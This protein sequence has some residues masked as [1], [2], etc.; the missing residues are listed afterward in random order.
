MDNIKSIYNYISRTRNLY[1]LRSTLQGLIYLLIFISVSFFILVLTDIAIHFSA[2]FL[3]IIHNTLF[4]LTLLLAIFYLGKPFYFWFINTSKYDQLWFAH[5]IGNADDTIDDKLTNILELNNSDIDNELIRASISQKL[6]V[7]N[8]SKINSF[9]SFKVLLKQIYFFLFV[10]FTLSL[11]AFL[12]PDSFNYSTQR[13]LPIIKTDQTLPYEIEIDNDLLEVEK[14]SNF[15]LRAKVIGMHKPDN[16]YIEIGGMQYFMNDSAQY[17]TYKLNSLKQDV[18]FKLVNEFYSSDNYFI[19]CIPVPIL[20]NISLQVIPP[21]YTGS[22]SFT[23]S[24]T[25]NVVFP[26]GSILQWNINTLDTDSLFLVSDSLIYFSNTEDNNY[27]FENRYFKDFNYGLLLKNNTR[28]KV[29]TIFFSA[30]VIPDQFPN[31][32]IEESSIDFLGNY[33]FRGEIS[34][35]YGFHQFDFIIKYEEETIETNIPLFSGNLSQSFQ[36][37]GTLKDF[38]ASIKGSDV[39]LVLR[40]KDNDPFYPFKAS[41]SQSLY[42][43]LPNQSELNDLEQRKVSMLKDKLS[44]GTELLEQL[45]REKANIRKKLLDNSSKWEKKQLSDQLQNTNQELNR[46]SEQINQLRED[47]KEFNKFDNKS[48]LFSKKQQ[49]EE[50]LNKLMDEELK[51]LMEELQKLQEEIMNNDMPKMD[52]VDISMDELEKHLDQNL[53]MLKRY[54]IEKQQDEVIQELKKLAQEFKD[55]ASPKTA[56]DIEKLKSQIDSTFKKHTDNLD[57]NKALEDPYEL[58]DFSKEKESIQ[59]QKD[60]INSNDDLKDKQKNP[61]DELEDLANKMEMNMDMAMQQQQG[62]DAAMI[63]DLLENLLHFSF[64]QEKYIEQFNNYEQFNLNELK[65]NQISLEERF[66]SLEDSLNA[67]MSRN[68][69]VALSIGNQIKNIKFNFKAIGGTFEAERFLSIQ[70]YQQ[71]IMQSANEL[72]L[73]LNESL[74][75]MNSMSGTGGQCK[76]KGSKSKPGMSGMKKKQEGM[77]KSLQ[78]MIDQL[79]KGS[80]PGEGQKGMSE[81]LSKM[82]GEQ[83]KLQQMLQQMMQ[84]GE[85][86]QSTRQL[87]QEINKMVDRN[88]DDIIKRNIDDNLVRRQNQILNRMLE[89]EIA[90]E[91]REKDKKREA[92]QPNNY[93]ISNPKDIFEYKEE[94]NSQKGILHKKKLPLKY[95]FQRKYDKYLNDVENN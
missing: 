66:S 48:D 55:T 42:G 79:K 2:F 91:E 29:D 5:Q 62:E 16:L 44:M 61:G 76:K 60:D 67:L 81:Q 47:L 54:E 23:V 75:Q 37:K 64:I 86:G 56:D 46:L 58:E 13:I 4:V 88:I 57:K 33:S 45:N 74:D 30:K 72:I 71:I 15:Y 3:S 18:S 39:E 26:Y 89:A 52:N 53:E 41:Y 19:K 22:E 35:D 90:E 84:S 20:K 38:E 50:L 28:N 27:T 69:M 65:R 7:I 9:F 8:I 10:L 82:L 32:K 87:L 68:A 49:L 73:L 34:D 85:V 40:I 36:Y 70:I 43:K 83:E 17:F 21:E 80:Q 92:E 31:I 94:Q 25:G 59:E 24:G 51:S 14:G 11:M 63:R 95:F 1:F 6:N 78:Q 12:N 77:K 93:E